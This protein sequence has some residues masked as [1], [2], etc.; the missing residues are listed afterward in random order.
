V[1]KKYLDTP[2]KRPTWCWVADVLIKGDAYLHSTPRVE[3]I[4]KAKMGTPK[5][6]G[7]RKENTQNSQTA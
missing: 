7:P 3:G 6:G 4:S 1:A 2:D 5:H